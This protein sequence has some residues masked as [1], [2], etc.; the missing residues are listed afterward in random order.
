MKV[1]ITKQSK[2][3]ITLA[4]APIA[5]RIIEEMKDDEM[6]V[7]EYAE[8]AARVA[9]GN[10]EYEILRASAEIAK[11][12]RAFNLYGEDTGN[13][14]IWLNFYA[15]NSYK[16]F[17]EIGAYLSD[18]WAIGADNTEEIKSHMYINHYHK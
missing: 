12:A 5:R 17:F 8:I 11:N 16:G 15:F 4:E 18:I 2:K 14:D 10:G 1:S 9:G 6:S 7:S 13:L 3:V